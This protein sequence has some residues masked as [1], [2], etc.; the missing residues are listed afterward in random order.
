MSQHIDQSPAAKQCRGTCA[1]ILPISSFYRR[2][3]AKLTYRP[4]CKGCWKLLNA[5]A[6][7]R[8]QEQRQRRKALLGTSKTSKRPA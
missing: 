8:R 4:I 7:M 6:H 2:G 3:T 1:A 5:A